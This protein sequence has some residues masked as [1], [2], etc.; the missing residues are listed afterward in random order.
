MDVTKK[1]AFHWQLDSKSQE[2]SCVI[3][4][5][6]FSHIENSCPFTKVSIPFD[7]LHPELESLR[8]VQISDI[9]AGTSIKRDYVQTVVE[10]VNSLEPDIIAF[11]GDAADGSVR[12]LREHVSPLADLS[13]RYVPY[14]VL[15][16]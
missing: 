8:I 1:K 6:T 3:N 5:Y 12:Y 11:T 9:H 7:N 15:L 14:F 2:H 13:A 4:F 16:Q 10:R